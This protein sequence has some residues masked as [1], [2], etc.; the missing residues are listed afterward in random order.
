MAKQGESL[1]RL[2]SIFPDDPKQI[3]EWLSYAD[4][5]SDIRQLQTHSDQQIAEGA[6]TEWFWHEQKIKDTAATDQRKAG[7][8]GAIREIS[9]I[10][11]RIWWI[12][13]ILYPWESNNCPGSN[14][15]LTGDGM[16]MAYFHVSGDQP[17]SE[18]EVLKVN[19]EK[20]LAVFERCRIYV[21]GKTTLASIRDAMRNFQFQTNHKVGKE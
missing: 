4:R 8:K 15:C 6:K 21:G 1:D 16:G 7:Y 20:L 17:D 18:V 19:D 5:W 3:A 9:K 13:D 14:C 11:D 10:C 2:L 12:A